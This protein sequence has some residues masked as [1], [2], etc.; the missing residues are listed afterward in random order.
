[1]NDYRDLAEKIRSNCNISDALDH[2]VYS[3][4]TMVLKLRNL[5]KWENGIEPW[6]EPEPGEL[7]DWIEARENFWERLGG[8]E[9]QP[10]EIDGEEVAPFDTD[11]INTMLGDSG[12]IY[13]AGYG[14]SLKAT[15]FLG[16]EEQRLEEAGCP[17]IIVGKELVR[18]M[19][20]P[21][22]MVQDGSIIVRR[23]PVRFF[24]WDQV[25]ELR[26]SC[27][28][29]FKYALDCYGLRDD[30]TLNQDRFRQLLDEIVEN[31]LGLFI[32]HEVG[33]MRDNSFDQQLNRRLIARFPGSVIEHLMRAVG[34]L[35]ADTHPD[36][37]L[38]YAINNR[39]NST[40]GFYVG[41][42]DGLRQVLFP[43]IN[44]WAQFQE[45]GD[46]GLIEEACKG[47]RE[48]NLA[49]V[50]RLAEFAAQNDT[51]PDEQFIESFMSDI[52]Q[53]LGLDN[54]SKDA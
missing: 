28:T 23:D 17:V 25:Q 45:S 15:F 14:R 52:L 34:D 31:E 5:Y 39:K 33:E 51:T 4:C 1:M 54:R 7:L 30:G 29:S 19:A 43:Q 10:L 42:L 9:Y 26:A 18:D 32:Y 38:S 40:L 11:K 36:G 50:D 16:H 41:F 13:G 49:L 6:Q 37:L 44:C 3:M 48:D 53:P 12:L 27:R 47:C 21:L 20:S 2:G 24:F 8:Q 46:W 22:A 35:L